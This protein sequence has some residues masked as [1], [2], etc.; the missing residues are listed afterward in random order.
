MA[1]RRWSTRTS[2]MTAAVSQIYT[3]EEAEEFPG[4]AARAV[5]NTTLDTTIIDIPSTTKTTVATTICLAHKNN[6]N[7]SSI[8]TN[9]NWLRSRRII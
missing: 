5:A 6:T 7:D 8:G 1:S 3:E 4:V 2:R 9:I